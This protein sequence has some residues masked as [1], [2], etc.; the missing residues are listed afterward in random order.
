M[1]RQVMALVVVLVVGA[2]PIAREVCLVACAGHPTGSTPH[3]HHSGAPQ[4]AEHA[5]TSEHEMARQPSHHHA[6][7]ATVSSAGSGCWMPSVA[8]DPECCKPAL[9]SPSSL[10]VVIKL[11]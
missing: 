5:V 4:P 2:T 7:E 3:A 1:P 8:T 9:D 11:A 10:A 6:D